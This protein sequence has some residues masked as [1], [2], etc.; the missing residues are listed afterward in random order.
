MRVIFAG[1][2]HFAVPSLEVL[3]DSDADVV[4]VL[5][6]PDRPAGRGRK[7][8]QSPV[9][10]V[11]LENNISVHQPISLESEV[12]FLRGYEPDIIIVVAY[13]LLIPQVILTL[14]ALGCINVHASL[15]PRW[16]GAAPIARAIEAG[17][18]ETGITL[19][20]MDAGLDTGATLLQQSLPILEIDTTR[21]LHDKL[22]KLGGQMLGKALPGVI[23]KTLRPNKQNN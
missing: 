18:N 12:E 22:A 14:P 23:N 1:T 13:G 17:D 4:L 8:Q 9:K 11:A 20:Q 6:Q 10:Q 3:I 5:T 7:L 16:R 15:L 2:P 21:S 19:M